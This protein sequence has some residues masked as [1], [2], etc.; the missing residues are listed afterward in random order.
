MHASSTAV[1]ALGMFGFA[2]ADFYIYAQTSYGLQDGG[3]AATRADGFKF[4]N[5]PPSCDDVNSSIYRHAV[6]DASY[7]GV[8]CKGCV[9]AGGSAN[10]KAS[11]APTLLEWNNEMGHFTWYADRNGNF[12]LSH[13]DQNRS[14]HFFSRQARVFGDAT[15]LTTGAKNSAN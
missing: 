13:V 10:P 11:R 5:G 9:N 1:L 2:T 12:V 6:D 15:T 7:S 3:G 8:R 14:V 4:Y